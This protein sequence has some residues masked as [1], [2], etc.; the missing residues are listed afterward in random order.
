MYIETSA[1]IGAW[2]CNFPQF[3]EIMTDQPANQPTN[4]RT[5]IGV[6]GKLQ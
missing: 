6:I 3:N 2:K 1:L 4:Q 5:D